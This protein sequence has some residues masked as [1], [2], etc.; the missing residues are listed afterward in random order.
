MARHPY[1]EAEA[2]R[3]ARFRKDAIIGTGGQVARRIAALG[4]ELGVDE[5]AIVTWTHDEEVRR[6]SY[7]LIAEAFGLGP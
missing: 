3:L 4:E 6:R 7:T 1:T 5:I 2:A